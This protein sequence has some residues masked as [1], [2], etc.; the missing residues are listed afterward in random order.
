[1]KDVPAMGSFGDPALMM[2]PITA[3]FTVPFFW[4]WSVLHSIFTYEVKNVLF[5]STS[6]LLRQ[7][8]YILQF[9]KS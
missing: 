6:N 4:V 1:M 8:L 3:P 9:W 5:Y 2:L 7:G